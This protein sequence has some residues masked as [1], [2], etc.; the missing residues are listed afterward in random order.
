MSIHG[1]GVDVAAVPRIAHLVALRGGAVAERWFTPEERRRCHADASP[2]RA[3]AET[4]AAKEAVWK[5][6]GLRGW[7]GSVPWQWIGIVPEEE[8]A[9]LTGPVAEAAAALHV[10]VRTSS[11]EAVAMAVATAS[12]VTP[13]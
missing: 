3:Y 10:H 7:D 9:H 5:A 8:T 6:L 4:F 2:S 12:P 1:I 11:T 13:R